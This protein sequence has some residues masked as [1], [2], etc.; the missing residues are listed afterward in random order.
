MPS[1]DRLPYSRKA[2]ENLATALNVNSAALWFDPTCQRI[3]SKQ[4]EANDQDLEY[5]DPYDIRS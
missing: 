4:V 3:T 2:L 1:L 5:N